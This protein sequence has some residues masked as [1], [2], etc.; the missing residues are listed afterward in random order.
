M[1]RRKIIII[2]CVIILV[3]ICLVTAIIFSRKEKQTITLYGEYSEI[4]TD[5]EEIAYQKSY[6]MMD[7]CEEWNALYKDMLKIDNLVAVE[8]YEIYLYD[9]NGKNINGTI[10]YTFIPT[11]G[12]SSYIE[13]HKAEADGKF[14][15][16]H[17]TEDSGLELISEN[18]TDYKVISEKQGIFVLAYTSNEKVEKPFVSNPECTGQC[19]ACE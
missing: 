6:L 9:Q 10:A 3:I 14:D 8:G 16:Y 12:F 7:C 19:R 18:S 1:S 5:N 2:I 15:I 17:W 11:K 13:K 4:T